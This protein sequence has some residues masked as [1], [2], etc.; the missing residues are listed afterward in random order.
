MQKLSYWL[1]GIQQ[2]C[3]SAKAVHSLWTRSRIISGRWQGRLRSP[4]T[5]SMHFASQFLI[6]RSLK[7]L[8]LSECLNNLPDL[9]SVSHCWH[10]LLVLAINEFILSRSN[11]TVLLSLCG[12]AQEGSFVFIRF[13]LK[14]TLERGVSVL[15]WWKQSGDWFFIAHCAVSILCA[16]FL[17][18]MASILLF[19]PQVQMRSLFSGVT[20]L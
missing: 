17:Q 8:L 7:C 5:P 14:T 9:H 12:M 19:L 10:L 18:G 20:L 11:P 15:R 2:S 13:L 3:Y 6:C 1:H 16:F 4:H